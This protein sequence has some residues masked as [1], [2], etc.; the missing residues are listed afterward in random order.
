M[1]GITKCTKNHKPQFSI[2][3][4]STVVT[5]RVRHQFKRNYISCLNFLRY[6]SVVV[7]VFQRVEIKLNKS[8]SVMHQLTQIA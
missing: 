8:S 7:I 3:C 6:K 4:V 1:L 2:E 5:C